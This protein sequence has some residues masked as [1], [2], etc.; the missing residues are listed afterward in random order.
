[1]TQ[2]DLKFTKGN[3]V[4]NF[5]KLKYLQRVY[6]EQF[7]SEVGPHFDEMVKRATMMVEKDPAINLPSN[8]KSADYVRAIL[9]ADAK[10]YSPLE[11]FPDRHRSFFTFD[12]TND[13]LQDISKEQGALILH[14][15]RHL[16]DLKEE[17]WTRDHI[18]SQLEKALDD[19]KLT[20]ESEQESNEK[21]IS[22]SLMKGL[23]K[24]VMDSRP[25]PPIADCL[26]ILGMDTA[27]T[28][29][30]RIEQIYSFEHM[31]K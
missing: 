1:M 9:K 31:N 23:R 8:R 15:Y 12:P 3:T 22:P 17:N 18:H 26:A 2:F 24:V 10:S 6:A 13:G 19:A 27:L 14:A 5:E 7:A 4:V 20:N 29:L 28:R 16:L 21:K 30:R 11:A 25:G